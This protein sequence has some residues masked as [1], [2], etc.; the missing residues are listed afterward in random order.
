MNVL[1]FIRDLLCPNYRT[2]K[3]DLTVCKMSLHELRSSQDDQIP[4][5]SW[6]DEAKKCY[7]AR[8]R[9]DTHNGIRTIEFD[10]RNLYE[11][12]PELKQ[13][14]KQLIID[15]R[16]STVD[17]IWN[18]VIK[19]ITYE[20]D[21]GEDWRFPT[22]THKYRRGDCEDSTILFITMLRAAG[23]RA[24]EVFNCTGWFD[25]GKNKYGHSFPIVRMGG[26]W[27]IFETT[28]NNRPD[29]WMPFT[30]SVYDAEWGLHNWKFA[31]KIKSLHST[32]T[33]RWQI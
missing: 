29:S 27:Y 20:L 17:S 14:T 13:I 18:Y 4:V 24:D 25:D 23:F 8:V 5:P 15:N 1:E 9:L 7:Q 10:P 19:Y 16:V 26:T 22:I 2:V 11:V 6:L 21:K 31:G 30:D 12:T 32:S 28:L 33:T 3:S